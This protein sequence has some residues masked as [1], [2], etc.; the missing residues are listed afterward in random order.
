MSPR[1]R[2]PTRRPLAARHDDAHE[3]LSPARLERMF[4]Y[5]AAWGLG[6]LLDVKD[7]TSLDAELRSFGANMPPA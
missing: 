4:L 7:R 1:L 2:A 6:G 3:S 5:C